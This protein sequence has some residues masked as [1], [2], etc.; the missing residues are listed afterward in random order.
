MSEIENEINFQ[1]EIGKFIQTGE[2]F[3]ANSKEAKM[4]A[5]RM[6]YDHVKRRPE[7][8]KMK[9]KER[10]IYWLIHKNRVGDSM[11]AQ[12]PFLLEPPRSKEELKI[13]E[14]PIE[15]LMEDYEKTL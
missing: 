10:L 2:I 11:L 1:F 4:F 13:I 8:D 5:K 12:P 15:K 7:I 14:T 6:W 9:R 3:R